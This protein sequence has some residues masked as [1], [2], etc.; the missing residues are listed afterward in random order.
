MN[1]SGKTWAQWINSIPFDLFRGRD[2]KVIAQ[3][4]EKPKFGARKKNS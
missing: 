2:V 1:E 4:E 3:P